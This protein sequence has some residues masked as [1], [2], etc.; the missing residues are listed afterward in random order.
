MMLLIY[1]FSYTEH[2]YDSVWD[3]ESSDPKAEKQPDPR[4]PV[5][6]RSAHQAKNTGP[7]LLYTFRLAPHVSIPVCEAFNSDLTL[8]T[9]VWC[10]VYCF[11][12]SCTRKVSVTKLRGLSCPYL[13][14]V[15]HLE[16]LILSTVKLS[17]LLLLHCVI[18]I[19]IHRSWPCHI[20]SED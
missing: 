15:Q 5:R 2:T 11:E 16:T 14:N 7:L 12:I 4:D 1:F 3:W 17:L 6:D 20:P 19:T 13:F 18:I 10:A 9:H 8:S